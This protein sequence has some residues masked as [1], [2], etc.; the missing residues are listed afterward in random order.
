MCIRDRYVGRPVADLIR[1]NAERG[2]LG[3]GPREEQ[4][5]KR[6]EYMLSLIH[7]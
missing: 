4:V 6:I 2:E 5:A 7:I 3:E 1:Y